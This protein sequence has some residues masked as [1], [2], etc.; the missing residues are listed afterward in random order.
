LKYLVTHPKYSIDDVVKIAREKQLFCVGRSYLE[1][2]KAEHPTPTPFRPE[3]RRHKRSQKFIFANGLWPF[4]DNNVEMR[5]A[6]RILDAARPREL[7]EC[8]IL[9][10]ISPRDI[11]LTVRALTG[12]KVAAGAIKLYQD[13]FWSL[14]LVDRRSIVVILDIQLEQCRESSDPDIRKQYKHLK[15]AARLDPRRL[16]ASLPDGEFVGPAVL[17]RIGVGSYVNVPVVLD[18][19]RSIALVQAGVAVCSGTARDAKKAEMLLR[20]A[21]IANELHDA[22]EKPEDRLADDLRK[23]TLKYDDERCKTFDE[24]CGAGN[25]TTDLMPEAQPEQ[26]PS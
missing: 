13:A 14:A 12:M 19:I 16:A 23:F 1:R 24:L 25:Y 4:Y 8:M 15:R 11:R 10:R 9:S 20:A 5:D 6:F 3:D 21:Q 7:T 17:N 22:V 26:A 2:L 18:K